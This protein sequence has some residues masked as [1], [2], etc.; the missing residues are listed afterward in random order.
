MDNFT[1]SI[2]NNILRRNPNI[3]DLYI[4]CNFD[5]LR[6]R[7]LIETMHV[8]VEMEKLK[9]LAMFG[10]YGVLPNTLDFLL[11]RLP[12]LEALHLHEWEYEEHPGLA[13]DLETGHLV[14]KDEGVDGQRTT[15]QPPPS[16]TP[17]R[18]QY[19][20]QKHQL[21]VP[22]AL[23]TLR[24]AD[25]NCPFDT[26]LKVASYS[27]LLN[28]LQFSNDLGQQTWPMGFA[29]QLLSF[30]PRLD[31]LDLSD[32]SL[33]K[34]RF[35]DLLTA[36]PRLRRLC[37][38]N[39]GPSYDTILGH[40]NKSLPVF[41]TTLE[42]V[43]LDCGEREYQ[44]MST[45][46]EIFIM[47]ASFPKLRKVYLK[48]LFVPAEDLVGSD[49]AL[50]YRNRVPVEDFSFA[51]KDLEV[52]ELIIQGPNDGWA[53]KELLDWDNDTVHDN[54]DLYDSDESDDD[55]C[56]IKP[57]T[58]P[59]TSP[60]PPSTSPPPVYELYEK[61]IEKLGMLPKLKQSG[62]RFSYQFRLKK[63]VKQK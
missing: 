57:P 60:P 24:I 16:P 9:K 48:N 7:D 5:E 45:C 42:E 36:L 53:P 30:C 1:I 35:K 28:R 22:R 51:C 23:R 15:H 63:S 32:T 29:Q 34:G 39:Q 11:D 8:L 20:Q 59:S 56:T 10:F 52:L 62:L 40:I 47:L 37:V 50:N 2:I 31:E 21:P 12:K 26:T 54:D 14:S 18:S 46:S 58:P 38:R 61:V 41:G 27:P 6:M 17:S 49:M 3:E 19:Q 25:S 13:L 44:D 33:Q 55:F 43:D 4:Q